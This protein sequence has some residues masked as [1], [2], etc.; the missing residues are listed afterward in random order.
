[1]IG[2]GHVIG[3]DTNDVISTGHII[4]TGHVYRRQQAA[5]VYL[6]TTL[7]ILWFWTSGFVSDETSIYLTP[8]LSENRW[9]SQR[10]TYTHTKTNIVGQRQCAKPN[11]Y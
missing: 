11:W 9:H 5:L 10:K 4:G 3:A 8:N 6:F 1:M 7:K 2:A